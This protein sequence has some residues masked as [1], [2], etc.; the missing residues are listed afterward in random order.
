MTD[1]YQ[2]KVKDVREGIAV[3]AECDDVGRRW[4][5]REIGGMLRYDYI[6][7]AGEQ[8]RQTS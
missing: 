6:M 5:G 2:G 3:K 1:G 7:T 4:N 8:E